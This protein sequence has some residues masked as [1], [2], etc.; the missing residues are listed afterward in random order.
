LFRL[1]DKNFLSDREYSRLAAAY[2]FLRNL[3]HRLQFY[4]DRQT[5]TIPVD[6]EQ[7]EILARRMPNSAFSETTA[8]SLERDLDEH[9]GAVRELYERVIRS[10]RA[11]YYTP[12][13]IAADASPE[14][15][16][17]RAASLPGVAP[18]RAD[19]PSTNLS[20]FLDQRAPSFMALLR[21]ARIVRGQER[22]EHFLEKIANDPRLLKALDTD[23]EMA[24]ATI[25]FFEHSP[26]FSDQLIRYPDL[27]DEIAQAC[28]ERQGRVGFDAPHDLAGLRRFYREQMVRIQSDSVYHRV[29]VYRT[30]K[31][32]SDLADSVIAAAYA[33]ALEEA[34]EANPP[35]DAHYR[36]SEQMMVIALGRLGMREFDLASDA[37]LVFA[38][39]DADAGEMAFWTAV[40]ERI[41]HVI[42]AYTGDGVIFTVDTRLRPNG[43]GG[44]L[45]QTE[46]A[47]KHYFAK[48][49][50][51]WEGIAYM[52]ARAVAGATERGTAFLNELQEVDWRRYGQNGR[53]RRQ[54]A[55]MRAKIEKEQGLRHPLKAG[56]GGYYDIDFALLY[57]RLR[58]AGIFYKV[59]NTPARIDIIEKMGHLDRE[60]ADFLRDAA[61][62]YRAID[63]GMR[64]ATGHAE[65]ALPTSPSRRAVLSD[66][67]CRWCPERLRQGTGGEASGEVLLKST[68]AEVRRRTRAFFDRIFS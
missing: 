32:T 51:A 9:L 40:A 47:F 53:S 66:L 42:S 6:S 28:G 13:E 2:Q 45:V 20:R 18:D 38:L 15:M 44:N 33:I 30:L 67:V 10:Q 35:A 21:G 19:F 50:E 62:F 46:E 52:K 49:A 41:I 14:Q 24:Q 26:Y 56:P 54:L 64:V 3:E 23:C 60:D 39:P 65:G 36:P 27:L 29:P 16:A 61:T 4:E 22:F 34:R 37:D 11:E 59:L 8:G 31:R 5:H 63:H 55:E 68:L 17:T 58:G 7:L 12:A 57:L 25:D 43:R 48:E 1:R